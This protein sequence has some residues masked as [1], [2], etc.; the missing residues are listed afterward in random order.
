MKCVNKILI[1][2]IITVLVLFLRII[3]V[4]QTQNGLGTPFIMLFIII[5]LSSI[6]IFVQNNIDQ[7]YKKNNL[8]YKNLDILKYV[9]SILI[10]ILHL[11]PFLNYSNELDLAF[12]NIITRICVPLFFLITGYFVA[13]KEKNNPIYIKEY[14]KKTIPLYLVWSSVYI[15]IIIG[16][17][18]SNISIIN[19]YISG[20]DIPIYFLMPIL[21][22]LIPFALLIGIFL[23]W[24]ILSFMVLSS[25]Y[26]FFISTIQMEEKI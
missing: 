9:S 6:T 14:I 3:N 4:F 7:N 16:Y 13:K 25:T 19:N 24:N 12:N 21:I 26:I 2:L 11:R 10:T 17:G 8:N 15:P 23:Y 1:I 18:I 20:I 5:L 22:L